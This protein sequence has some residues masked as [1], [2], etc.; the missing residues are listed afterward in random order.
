MDA[1]APGFRHRIYVPVRS[2]HQQDTFG[3]EHPEHFGKEPVVI[4][5][6]LE[7]LETGHDVEGAVGELRKLANIAL[8]EGEVRQAVVCPRMLDGRLVDVDCHH[9]VRL[10]REHR[11]AVAL[12]AGEVEYPAPGS[13]S[14]GEQVP[15]IVL[16]DHGEVF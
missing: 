3:G 2:G 15:V 7:S 9:L 4:G 16:V 6:V 5:D 14:G 11:R 8:A 1:F 12:A 10:C 13:E